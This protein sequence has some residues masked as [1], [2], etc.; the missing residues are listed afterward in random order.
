MLK[1]LSH[2]FLM[3]FLFGSDFLVGKKFLLPSFRDCLKERGTVQMLTITREAAIEVQVRYNF[4]CD[5]KNYKNHI[6]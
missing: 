2:T 1:E 6:H 5:K 3:S 4:S